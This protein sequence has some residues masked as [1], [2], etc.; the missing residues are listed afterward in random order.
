MGSMGEMPHRVPEDV[1]ELSVTELRDNLRDYLER[2]AFAE[3]EFVVSRAGKPIAALISMD[4]YVTLRRMIASFENRE[5]AL[6]AT[7]ARKSAEYVD[8]ADVLRGTDEDGT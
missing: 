7:A 3:D 5:D 6:A 8:L 2:V 4:A 1:V